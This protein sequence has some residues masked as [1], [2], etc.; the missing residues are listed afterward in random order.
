MG[1]YDDFLDELDSSADMVK[2]GIAVSRKGKKLLDYWSPV[3][4]EQ[5]KKDEQMAKLWEYREY[6]LQ[7]NFKILWVFMIIGTIL[8]IIFYN[9][10][11]LWLGMENNDVFTFL[12]LGGAF[13]I[14]TLI[15]A[16][17]LFCFRK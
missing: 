5:R 12:V 9:E 10:I 17:I 14:I 8:E 6:T 2:K 3:N 16:A 4:S 7:G 15:F 13:I 11:I 1:K